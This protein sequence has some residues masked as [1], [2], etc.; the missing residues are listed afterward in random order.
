MIQISVR[1]RGKIILEYE[2]VLRGV[3]RNRVQSAEISE[4]AYHN[5]SVITTA[6]FQVNDR[7]YPVGKMEQKIFSSLEIVCQCSQ[8]EWRY[9]KKSRRVQGAFEKMHQYSMV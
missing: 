3:F 1:G 5:G 8:Y 6:S 4:V 9:C 2:R 7:H